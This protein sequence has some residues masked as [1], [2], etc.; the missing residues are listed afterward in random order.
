[1][2]AFEKLVVGGQFTGLLVDGAEETPFVG[3]S[4]F[5]DA[6]RGVRVVVPF[7]GGFGF[8]LGDDNSQFS[9]VR[10]WFF[11]DAAPPNLVFV[12]KRAEFTLFGVRSIGYSSNLSYAEG[13]LRAAVAVE[14]QR[15]YEI[16]LDAP[17]TFGEFSS[18][19]SG[20]YEWSGLSAATWRPDLDDEGKVV[21][22]SGTVETVPP[23]SWVQ[24]EAT[25][26][27]TSNWTSTNNKPGLHVDEWLVLK[28]S[29]PSPRSVDDHLKEQRKVQSFVVLMV[30][31]AVPFA[32]HQVRDDGFAV[33]NADRSI[34]ER[35]LREVLVSGTVAEHQ[36][37]ASIDRN[38]RGVLVPFADVGVDG[39]ERW[40][41]LDKAWERF[42]FPA[43]GL[44]S[45]DGVFAEDRVSSLSMSLEA[46]GNLLGEVEGERATYY[47]GRPVTKTW[48]FRCFTYL[49]WDCSGFA[50]STAGLAKACADNYNSIKHYDRG[51]FPDLAETVLV[52]R[53]L[54]ATVRSLALKLAKPDHVFGSNG[55]PVFR[56]LVEHF[57]HFGIRVNGEGKWVDVAPVEVDDNL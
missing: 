19:L 38:R 21:R 41:A 55:N 25:M 12:S 27:L 57:E 26:T 24:G 6:D 34:V 42:I 10:R 23:Q 31:N 11:S 53:V 4:L 50:D 3:A 37:P 48:F 40:G 52:G 51:D 5:L 32:K 33:R 14:G 36:Q 15:D 29:F 49:G 43:V 30:G 2:V 18:Q 44:L 20:L 56:D 22:L 47:R 46:A 35:P 9:A 54:G 45:R 1:V 13:T 8:D 28:S 39:L 7:R 16:P 17:L